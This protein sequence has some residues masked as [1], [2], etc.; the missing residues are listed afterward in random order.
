M[1]LLLT[2]YKIAELQENILNNIKMQELMQQF[3]LEDFNFDNMEEN[4]KI[5]KCN[6]FGL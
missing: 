3:L 2:T 1:I 6:L 5:E 4:L